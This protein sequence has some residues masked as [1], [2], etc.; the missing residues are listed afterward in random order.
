MENTQN[1]V[2]D[3]PNNESETRKRVL[4]VRSLVKLSAKEFETIRDGLIDQLKDGVVVLPRWLEACTIGD[5]E[6][7]T[8]VEG[9][10]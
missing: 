9:P 7:V 8:F 1:V 5:F 3:G 6:E 4:V 10:I 2:P